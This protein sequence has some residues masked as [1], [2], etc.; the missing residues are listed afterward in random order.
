MSAFVKEL[1]FFLGGRKATNI[2]H[3]TCCSSMASLFILFPLCNP[4]LFGACKHWQLGFCLIIITIYYAVSCNLY[5]LPIKF[6]MELITVFTTRMY[7]SIGF[8]SAF[9]LLLIPKWSP[10]R[11]GNKLGNSFV[12]KIFHLLRD[13]GIREGIYPL[14]NFLCSG[15]YPLFTFLFFKQRKRKWPFFQMKRQMP[16]SGDELFLPSSFKLRKYLNAHHF[17]CFTVTHA[18]NQLAYFKFTSLEND[19]MV[20]DTCSWQWRFRLTREIHIPFLCFSGEDLISFSFFSW[21]PAPCHYYYFWFLFTPL[22]AT[23]TR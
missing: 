6:F 9:S 7:Y 21:H 14:I 20:A 12:P 8:Y 1:G 10:A 17:Y 16:S 3:C 18:F 23:E 15:V 2:F 11:E 19:S 5:V 4:Y 13:G 22:H